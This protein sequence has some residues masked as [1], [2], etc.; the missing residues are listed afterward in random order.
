M[1]ECGWASRGTPALYS[2]TMEGMVPNHLL[3]GSRFKFCTIKFV[4]SAFGS[5]DLFTKKCEGER[6][7]ATCRFR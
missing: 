3:L 4:R 5:S 2:A 1:R 7:R 6:T